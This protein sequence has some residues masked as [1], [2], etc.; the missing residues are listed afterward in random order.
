MDENQGTSLRLAPT[1]SDLTIAVCTIGRDGFLQ[2]ALRSLLDTTPPGVI[3]RVVLNGPDNPSLADDVT[4]IVEGWDGPVHIRILPERLSIAGSHN[5][6]L[7]ET[8]TDFV[9]FMGD[10]DLVLEPRVTRLLD[11]FW[12]TTP[13]PA[14]IGSFCRR[15]SGNHDDPK[16]STNKDYGP[17]SIDEWRRTV[18]SGDLIEVVFPSAI[19]RTELLNSIGGFEERFGSAMDLATFTRLGLDHPV[20]ADPRRTFAHRIH[21]GSVTSSSAGQH[22][23]RL[24]YTELCLDA[25]R[26][27]TPEPEWDDFV[28]KDEATPRHKRLNDQR[29]IL[30]ATLFRQGGAA[31]ASG[32]RLPGVGKV[33]ASALLSPS[34]FIGRSRSQVSKEPA[35]EPVVSILIKNTNQ[36]RVPLYDE[37]RTQLAGRGVELRLIVAEGLAEDHAKGDRASL[38]WAEIRPFHEISIRG[39]T[40][41]WQPGFDIASGSDLI[42]TE[43]ASKQL[44][45]VV[46][47]YG[48]RSFNTRHA[49]WGHGKN[50]QAAVEGSSGEGLKR[51][52]TSKAHW[53]FAY[54]EL[55]ARAAAEAGMPPERI[56]SVMNTTDTEHIRTVVADLPDDN[57]VTV[58]RELGMGDGPVGVFMG[59]IYPPKRTA[60]LLDAAQEIRRLVPDFELLLIGGGSERGLVEEAD[61]QHR[62]VHYVGPE[63]GDER[64]RLASV[65]SIQLMPGM[66]GLNIVDAFA[67]G[68]PTITTDIEYHSPEIDYLLDGLNGSIVH[69][70]PSP[71]D[72]AHYVAA[73]LD[74]KTRLAAL[75]HAAEESGRELTIEKMA[76]NFANGI[77]A[78]LEADKR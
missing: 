6:A 10:D 13:T 8:T 50:F 37:L 44:F 63:Y 24:R 40:L 47:A 52:L 19:Y 53:F 9:T 69:G 58:R 14:V 31:M 71:A 48:Q 27:G 60:Y 12:S 2:T 21:D 39:R 49:F 16:F 76:I 32:S 72:F 65:G 75:Q 46:L 54:N 70:D 5:T 23:A 66:V 35:G 20:L 62:W 61:D 28:A 18:A 77:L 25:V 56:T 3:L 73:L 55:S 7:S 11:L 17:V 33:A 41:L 45:N 68:L 78:A 51:R 29:R 42:I 4:T 30:S 67:L 26:N 43:Q 15:V 22:A 74:D 36:Y 59:G 64:L 57:T 1:P 34:T 38:P